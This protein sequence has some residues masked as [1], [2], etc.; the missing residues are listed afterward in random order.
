MIADPF[1]RAIDPM[2]ERPDHRCARHQP[3][4]RQV[5]QFRGNP[6]CPIGTGLISD[7]QRFGVGPPPLPEIFGNYALVDFIEVVRD[8][9]AR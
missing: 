2:I 8:F 9:L 3:H 6:G 4:V 5:G 7:T 1:D